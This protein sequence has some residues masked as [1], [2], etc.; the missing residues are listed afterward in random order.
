MNI[1]MIF[2]GIVHVQSKSG[3]GSL[4]SVANSISWKSAPSQDKLPW[5][6][7]FRN[8]TSTEQQCENR[9]HKKEKLIAS[10]QVTKDILTTV[11]MLYI[12]LYYNIEENK[13]VG[14]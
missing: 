1:I 8:D 13:T 7:E 5:N 10:M 14:E 2:T 9:S 11:H 4:N 12:H 3:I 6:V